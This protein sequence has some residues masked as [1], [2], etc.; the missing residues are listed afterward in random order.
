[1]AI[2]VLCLIYSSDIRLQDPAQK[3]PLDSLADDVS[4]AVFGLANVVTLMY[5]GIDAATQVR[6]K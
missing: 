4:C 5:Y 1:M 2:C 3:G 6:N